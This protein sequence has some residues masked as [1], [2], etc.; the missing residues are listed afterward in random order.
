MKQLLIL[1]ALFVTILN[2]SAQ[3]TMSLKDATLGSSSYLKPATPKQLKWKDAR[4]YVTVKKN[5]LFQFNIQ[6]NDSTELLSIADLNAALTKNG[7]K[8]TEIFPAFTF[9]DESSIWFRISKHLVILNLENKSITTSIEYPEEAENLDLS[10]DNSMLAYTFDNNLYITGTSGSQQINEDHNPYIINGAAVHRNEFG[11]EK[12][13][14]WSPKGSQLA[15]YRMDETMVG[16][17]PLVDYMTREAKLVNIKYPMAGMT[18]HQVKL[19]IYNLANKQIVFMKTGEPLDHYLTNISWSPDEKTIFIAELNREQNHLKLNQYNATTGDLVKTV[20]EETDTRYVEPLHPIVFSKNDPEKFY[21][22]SRRDGW[23]HVYLYNTNG[24]KIAQITSGNWEV[25]ELLGCDADEKHLFFEAT[26]E[27]PLERHLYRINIFSGKI[28]RLTKEPG[29]HSG[30]LSPDSQNLIDHWTSTHVPGRID[31]ISGKGSLVKT[32]SEA[33]N[34]LKDYDLGENTV[35]TIKADDGVTDL[36][37]RMIKPN[38]FDP[39]KKYPVIVYVYGGPH[40]Q[41]ISKTWLNDARWWQYYMASKGYIAFTVDNR[42]S[43]NRGKEFENVIHRQLGV[44]ETAD[45]MKGIEYLKSLPY[46]DNNRIGVHG[47][48]FGGFMTLNLM[49]KHPETFKVGVAGGPVV[50]WSMYEV[51]YG[52]RYMDTPEENPL[53]YQN[54]NMLNFVE[55]LQGKLMLIHGVQDQTVVMQHSIQFLKKCVDLGK[56]VDFFV[57]PTHEHNVRGNDRLHLMEKISNYFID[58]L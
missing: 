21:Y 49:L 27:S 14:F 6:D 47:W 56:Q 33:Q 34:T 43:S 11:I 29:T 37:C 7:I 16:D 8:E 20:L 4:H 53:G 39:A 15:F 32:I 22:Q 10:T 41:L 26:R 2:V 54:S 38:N 42:G 1:L 58:N 24:K 5:N 23:N 52:E 35:F 50:D 18:S 45:Q 51:M 19:G 57:Y 48:S 44:V 28:D 46:I 30:I 31:L 40:T 3:Q 9:V 25:T 55:K 17:Y 36:Y 12:G 13:T